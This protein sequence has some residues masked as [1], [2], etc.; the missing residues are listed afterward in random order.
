M[1]VLR[2]VGFSFWYSE[3]PQLANGFHFAQ[4]SFFVKIFHVFLNTPRSL[5]ANFEERF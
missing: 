5:T 3:L 4:R 1:K 2:D